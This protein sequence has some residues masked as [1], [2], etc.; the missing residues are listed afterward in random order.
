ME[1]SALKSACCHVLSAIFRLRRFITLILLERLTQRKRRKKI[2]GF[3]VLSG[4][5]EVCGAQ[6]GV[7]I[8]RF[9]GNFRSRQG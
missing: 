1:H 6:K 3:C 4:A 7:S 8:A 9:A 2:A 5:D